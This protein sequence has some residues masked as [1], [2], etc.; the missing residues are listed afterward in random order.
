LF[1]RLSLSDERVRGRIEVRD[2][3]SRHI[4]S[5]ALDWP[6]VLLEAGRNYVTE[7]DSVALR[8]HYV[9]LN[10]DRHPVVLRGVGGRRPGGDVTL[11]PGAVWIVPAGDPVTL[12]A[13]PLGLCVRLAIEPRHADAL[14]AHDRGDDGRL[15]LRRAYDVDV[16]Q[17]RHLVLA[18]VA[19]ADARTSSGLAFVEILTAAIGRQLVAHAGVRQPRGVP[20]RGGLSSGA[21]RRVL[22]LIDAKLD[23]RLS[24]DTLAREAGLSPAHFARA[25]KQA[26]GQP[27]H[28]FLLSR[29]LERARRMLEESAA[30]LSEVA[31]Q[32]GFADQAHFTR[33]FKRHF[34]VTPGALVRPFRRCA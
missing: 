25:F 22:E 28:R 20:A 6:G 14:L 13:E 2:D 21:R 4:A 27:P 7:V 8:H 15:E 3:A 34:G 30:G 18:L 24:V 9:G 12:R 10:A 1:E 17:L 11:A 16:P 29:R 31:A 26:L 33:H 19:E 23:A 32:W 5:Q